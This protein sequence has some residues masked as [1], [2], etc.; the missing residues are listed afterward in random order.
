M[1]GTL[2]QPVHDFDSI[3]GELG[4]GKGVPILE[5]IEKMPSAEAK[6]ITMRLNQLEMDLAYQ[7]VAQ[8]D[9][10]DILELLEASGKTL[11]ILTRNS[12]EIADVTLKACGLDR[13]FPSKFIIGRETC[14]PK[15]SPEGVL[16]LL[17]LWQ[18]PKERAVIIGD[19]RYDMEAG[20]YSNINTVHLDHSG[21]FE[22]PQFTLHGIRSLNQLRPLVQGTT[23]L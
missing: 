21:L 16:Y 9:A 1:D 18:A 22:W 2:T 19:Y 3:R 11:G 20:Y 14:A 23:V 10:E 7:A 15:P 6:R 5:A 17:D 4:I 13:F 8:P 12:E